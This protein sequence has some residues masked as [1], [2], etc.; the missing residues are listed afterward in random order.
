[1]AQDSGGT[2]SRIEKIVVAAAA[3]AAALAGSLAPAASPAGAQALPTLQI[4]DPTLVEGAAGST[5][6]VE[7]VVTIA[8]TLSGPSVW[9][10][11]TFDER[12]WVD[13]WRPS[14]PGED[15]LAEDGVLVFAPGGPTTQTITVTV[16]DDT[17]DEHGEFLAVVAFPADEEPD[18]SRI[19]SG[20]AH[21]VDDDPPP[22]LEPGV[23]WITEGEGEGGLLHVPLTMSAPSGFDVFVRWTTL[24]VAG[25][26]AGQ[27]LSPGDYT[28]S[29]GT[30]YFSPYDR[31]TVQVVE[32]PIVDD[33]LPEDAE[34][35]VVSFTVESGGARMGGY[36]GLGFGGIVDND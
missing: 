21:I 2:L 9:R 36:W 7:Y 25:A 16:L 12:D 20:V 11:G 18:F 1:V 4:S 5:T 23:G 28:A 22:V 19:S 24:N 14:T 33:E 10:W 32:I 29:S 35:V 27:A 26:P 17:K 34:Y 3:V 31:D 6:E 13:E 15:Y 8:G 30:L